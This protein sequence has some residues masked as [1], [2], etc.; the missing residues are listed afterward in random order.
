M[1]AALLPVK[2]LDQ[3]K[4]RLGPTFD[5]EQRL[6]IARALFE[7][8]LALADSVDFLEWWV[9]SDDDAVLERARERGHG[10]IR[11]Q[12]LG[13]NAAVHL[14]AGELLAAGATTLTIIHSDI[15][16]AWAGD[17]QDLVD[18]GATSDVVVVPSES[19]GGTNALLL[20]PPDALDP[21]FGPGSLTEHLKAA[22]G[23]GLRC[24]L[25]SL[26]RL[27]LDLDTP[28]DARAL[29]AKD[30]AGPSATI[31]LLKKLDLNGS[32]SSENS[33]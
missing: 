19:D 1:E 14:A 27:A 20:A 30:P 5:A 9:V 18:T 23:R 32:A 13:L 33:P 11:D 17:L 21:H 8:S 2:R 24:S 4:T 22:E 12:G 15:P 31:D 29:A 16:L 3:A 28:A 10:A 6:A 7:D 26:P 25:L